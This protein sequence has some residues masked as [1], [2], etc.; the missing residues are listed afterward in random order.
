MTPKYTPVVDKYNSTAFRMTKEM[1]ELL[2]LAMKTIGY[3]SKA[4]FIREAI[5][6]KIEKELESA[7]L[8][9][10]EKEKQKVLSLLERAK[11]DNSKIKKLRK[12]GVY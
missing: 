3:K 11:K 12:R 4:V 9:Y 7:L 8:S 2:L 5:M 1:N 10:S 6:E